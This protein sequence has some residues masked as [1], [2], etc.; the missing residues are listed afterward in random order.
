LPA[1][2]PVANSRRNSLAAP[3]AGWGCIDSYA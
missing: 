2:I 3:V 1:A